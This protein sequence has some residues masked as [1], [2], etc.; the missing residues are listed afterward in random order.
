MK[1][2]DVCSKILLEDVSVN[3][4]YKIVNSQ[5]YY[6]LLGCFKRSILLDKEA[7]KYNTNHWDGEIRAGLANCLS[8]KVEKSYKL[9]K[10]LILTNLESGLASNFNRLKSEVLKKYSDYINEKDL[11][12]DLVKT[13]ANYYYPAVAEFLFNTVKNNENV[14]EAIKEF[15]NNKIGALS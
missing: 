1:L 4:F 5:S 6:V 3:D 7:N 15:L 12:F 9:N 10:E 11:T 8:K 2:S 13:V 14:T